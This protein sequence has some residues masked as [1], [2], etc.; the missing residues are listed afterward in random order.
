VPVTEIN[1]SPA[2]AGGLSPPPAPQFEA[3]YEAVYD[4]LSLLGLSSLVELPAF[5]RLRRISFLGALREA[6]LPAPATTNNRLHHTLGVTFLSFLMG[7]RAGLSTYNLRHYVASSIL[8]DIGNRALSHTCEGAFH[9]LTGIS[10]R[11]VRES[12]ILGDSQVVPRQYS[13][14]RVLSLMKLD[15]RLLLALLRRDT[16]IASV[17]HRL[18]VLVHNPINPDTL[19]G[20]ARLAFLFD[21]IIPDPVELI[22]LFSNDSSLGVRGS[23]VRW[24]DHFWRMKN[25]FYDTYINASVGIR[26]DEAFARAAF[27]VYLDKTPIDIYLLT[28]SDV[29]TDIHPVL[30][31]GARPDDFDGS[32]LRF[33]PPTYYFIDES[34]VVSFPF[35]SAITLARRYRHSFLPKGPEGALGAY[36]QRGD[37]SEPTGCGRSR[38]VRNPRSP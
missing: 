16:G 3:K 26:R 32:A 28:D 18:H 20:I 5:Q 12:L 2:P 15:T 35:N 6:D 30:E 23:N 25:Y 24:L 8:H 22:H 14:N 9:K 27:S 7:S 10:D 1:G 36:R 13:L 38:I 21:D 19:D 29:Y 17:D 33:R 4:I 11:Q 37:L 31:S 34:I